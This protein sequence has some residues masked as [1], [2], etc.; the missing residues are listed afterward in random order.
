[1]IHIILLSSEVRINNKFYISKEVGQNRVKD[2]S[3]ISVLKNEKVVR[4]CFEL[5]QLININFSSNIYGEKR[6]LEL[7]T[8]Y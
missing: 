3:N 7:Q 5:K 8:L 1:M 4:S 2:V 6:D